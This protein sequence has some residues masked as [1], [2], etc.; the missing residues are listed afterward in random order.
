MLPPHGALDRYLA[1]IGSEQQ[2]EMHVA[3]GVPEVPQVF[4]VR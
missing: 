1:S 3:A 4:Q 2:A